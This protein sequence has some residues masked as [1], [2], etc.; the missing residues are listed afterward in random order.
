MNQTEKNLKPI[1]W[2][3]TIDSKE[4]LYRI[5]A[6]LRVKRSQAV[7]RII[8]I[9]FTE[10]SED[11]NFKDFV[12]AYDKLLDV[13]KDRST[14]TSFYI[15]AEYMEKFEDMMYKFGFIDRSPFLRMIINYIYNKIVKP[16][17]EEILPK[18]KA[19]IGKL[20][21]QILGL[22]PLLNGDIYVHIQS[23]TTQPA[24]GDKTG[25]S[26]GN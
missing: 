4:Q 5:A 19:D 11:K 22:G 10:L 1:G 15:P 6:F 24:P 14:Y 26:N 18:V 7:L 2:N 13:T 23:P 25:L 21:Y 8:D 20:G 12:G 3:L 16:I 17:S 9:L